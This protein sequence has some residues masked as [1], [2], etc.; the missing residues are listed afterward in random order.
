MSTLVPIPKLGQSEE[1]VK[2]E[3]WR[4]KEGDKIKKGDVLFEVETDK[5]V[6]EVESQFEGT[7][8]KI[9]VQEGVEVPVMTTALI[10][11]EPGETIPDIK[12]EAIQKK[13]NPPVNDTTK[14][15]TQEK[16]STYTQTILSAKTSTSSTTTEPIQQTPQFK[17]KPSP[18]ARQFAKNFLINLDDITGTGGKNRRVTEADVKKY[19]E[20]SGY[21]KKKITGAAFNLAK[22]EN[23][24]IFQ[25]EGSGEDG[26]ITLADVK[27]AIKEKPKELTSIRKII[28][29]R[30]SESKRN[31]PHF[32][33]TVS[34][35]LTDLINLRKKLKDE[36]LTLS[37][38][39]FIIKAT[40]LSL[41][42]FPM[43]NSECN[44]N[45]VKYKSKI[46]IGMAVSL[47]GGLV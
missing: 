9:V 25:I 38:N 40:S 22:K 37:I 31:I 13:V 19:L 17:A 11:G 6:L 29:K 42:E 33:V 23:L 28:A 32:Y 21:F 27:D 4:V 41:R 7:V 2:I 36:G 18:R 8:L 24:T 15:S 14:T 39:D 47:E 12:I 45:Y 10:L 43:L 5:A 44:E 16:T 3:K 34:V 46:N 20:E 1:T 35:D 26:R 30:L